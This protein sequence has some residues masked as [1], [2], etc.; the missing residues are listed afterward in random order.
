M[1]NR[2]DATALVTGL[3]ALLIAVVAL[4]STFTAVNPSDL[5]AFVPALLVVFGL[6]GLYVSRTQ[7]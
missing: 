5:G 6:V 2:V 3:V 7:P 4:A 1:R